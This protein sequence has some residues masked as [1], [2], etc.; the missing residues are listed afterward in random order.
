M[1]KLNLPPESKK[2]EKILRNKF[3]FEWYSKM[4]YEDYQVEMSYYKYLGLLTNPEGFK[5]IEELNNKNNGVTQ[6]I[7]NQMYDNP[8]DA[9]KDLEKLGISKINSG[10]GIEEIE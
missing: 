7:E 4:L 3:L 5:K 2:L 8:E 1:I 6:M 10:E 9:M